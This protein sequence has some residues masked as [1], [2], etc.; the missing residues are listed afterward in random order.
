MI[1]SL[2]GI[3][4]LYLPKSP[5]YFVTFTAQKM[6]FLVKDFFI[7]CDQIS[8]FLRIWSYLLKKSLMEDFNFC[9]V[10]HTWP[11]I[12]LNSQDF[13]IEVTFLHI[14]IFKKS[15]VT[16]SKIHTVISFYAKAL[17]CLPE[18]YFRKYWGFG[19]HWSNYIL[20]KFWK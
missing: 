11:N 17:K 13:V 8:S 4:N 14:I 1:L 10:F 3:C 19:F 12:L 18:K 9:E 2:V 6:K 15:V 20:S 5:I 7:K 16:P